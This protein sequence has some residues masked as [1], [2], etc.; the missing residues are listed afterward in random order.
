MTTFIPRLISSL[1]TATLTAYL[2]ARIRTWFEGIP[3]AQ[4]P[5]E[6]VLLGVLSGLLIVSLASLLKL[7]L[8]RFLVST[9][10]EVIVAHSPRFIHEVDEH[11]SEGMTYLQDQTPEDR[12]REY[13]LVDT[14]EYELHK[15]MV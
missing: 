14:L 13:S 12:R 2:I 3:S 4:V 6:A 7:V 11:H 10:N 1:V 9:R 15:E 5:L 8:G